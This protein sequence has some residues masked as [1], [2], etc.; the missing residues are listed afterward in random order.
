MYL[1]LYHLIRFLSQSFRCHL[2][3]SQDKHSEMPESVF[4]SQSWNVSCYIH[5]PL[6]NLNS[7]HTLAVRKM[8]PLPVENDCVV[9]FSKGHSRAAD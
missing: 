1:V 4:F 7:N 6:I 5:T 9:H 8:P 2:S 3:N